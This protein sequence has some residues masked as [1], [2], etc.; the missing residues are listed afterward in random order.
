MADQDPQPTQTP[1]PTEDTAIK[2]EENHH[3]LKIF[4]F[5]VFFTGFIV[6][7]VYLYRKYKRVQSREK[8]EESIKERAKTAIDYYNKVREESLNVSTLEDEMPDNHRGK[9]SV[10]DIN[11]ELKKTRAELGMETKP[12]EQEEADFEDLR[13]DSPSKEDRE[14]KAEDTEQIDIIV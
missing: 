5:I 7:V 6:L 2:V 3:G 10:N 4:F 1:T 14:K 12:K 8:M 13:V 11:K 9:K